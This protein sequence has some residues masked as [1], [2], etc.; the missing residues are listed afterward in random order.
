MRGSDILWLFV[1]CSQTFFAVAFNIEWAQGPWSSIAPNLTD[2][3]FFFI[4]E[5][6]V[7]IVV[8]WMW[9][10]VFAHRRGGCLGFLW[11]TPERRPH[12]Q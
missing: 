8:L 10:E 4:S 1:T 11:L 3:V 2:A 6:S 5:A 7:V 12:K 9:A